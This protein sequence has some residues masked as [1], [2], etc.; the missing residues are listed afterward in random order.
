MPLL[1]AYDAP[2]SDMERGAILAH[3]QARAPY[4]AFVAEAEETIVGFVLGRDGRIAHHIGPLVAEGEPIALA[5]A[6]QAAIAASPPFIVDVPGRHAGLRGW[7][8]ASGAVSPRG[9]TRMTLGAA[10]GLGANERI[11]A[12]AGPELA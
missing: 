9:F 11:F 5:L 1:G 6:A 3:L 2:R 4:L 8:E 12:I 10:P 7:L